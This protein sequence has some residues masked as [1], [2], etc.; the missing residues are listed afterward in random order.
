M[1]WRSLG[2]VLFSVSGLDVAGDL[3][4]YFSGLEVVGDL[5][6]YFSGLEVV[7]EF[8]ILFQ[9]FG[10]RWGVPFVG[11]FLMWHTNE[12]IRDGM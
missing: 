7:G 3:L 2:S 9:W 5:L 6:S 8:I 1:A 4:S 12:E 11:F 10:G